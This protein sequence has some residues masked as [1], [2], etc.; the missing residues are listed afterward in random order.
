MQIISQLYEMLSIFCEPLYIVVFISVV[1]LFKHYGL[2]DSQSSN[3]EIIED[4]TD[5]DYYEQIKRA[6]IAVIGIIV[7]IAFWLI[8]NKT[9]PHDFNGGIYFFKLLVSYAISTT[10]YELIV[11]YILKWAKSKLKK[12]KGK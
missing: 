5:Y 10:C 8:K 2:F 6:S 9:N 3:W 7:A 1:Q 12:I 4:V 11:K